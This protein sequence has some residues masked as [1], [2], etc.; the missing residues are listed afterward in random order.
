MAT[1]KIQHACLPEVAELLKRRP[2]PAFVVE[3]GG[4]VEAKTALLSSPFH[5][6]IST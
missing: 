1:R 4:I 5:S 2:D 3:I 6:A